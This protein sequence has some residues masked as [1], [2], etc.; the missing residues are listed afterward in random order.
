VQGLLV[1]IPWLE[2]GLRSG[3]RPRASFRVPPEA[4]GARLPCRCSL[5]SSWA[6]PGGGLVETD[7][8]NCFFRDFRTTTS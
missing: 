6:G 1:K 5:M 4:V 2:A 8:A 7:I 3:L